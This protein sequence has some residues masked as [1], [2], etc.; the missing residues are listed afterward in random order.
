[1][2]AEM[3]AAE[4]GEIQAPIREFAH[5]TKALVFVPTRAALDLAASAGAAILTTG[6]NP[7]NDSR[8]NARRPRMNEPEELLVARRFRVVRHRELAPDG[9][10]V[11]RETVQHPGSVAI[12]P[13]LDDR[14]V[15]LI[16]NRRVAVGKTLVELPAGTL[17]S[18]EDPKAT[19]RRELAEE[20]GYD[21]ATL[22]KLCEF[23]MSPGILNERMHLFVARGLVPGR[24]QLEPGEEIETLVVPWDAAVRMAT[25]GTIEDAKTM[26]G[27]LFWELSLR[28]GSD[29]SRA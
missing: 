22:D 21:A 12:L 11:V 28:A 18:G 6:Q 15:C 25:D 16:R 19:A 1:M 7:I 24:Q 20:T 13:L 14:K 3:H 10:P 29:R 17:E 26:L 27:I 5:G 2:K 9:T 4:T 23:L 8:Y